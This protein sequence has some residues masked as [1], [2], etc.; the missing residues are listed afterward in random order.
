MGF[1]QP[2]DLDGRVSLVTGA[3]SG[4]G[5]QLAHAMASAGARVMCAD[6]N[7]DGAQRTADQLR[8]SGAEA[9]AATC[10]V[11]QEGEVE[12]LVAATLRRFGQIDILFN[13]AGVSES[14]PARAHEYATE[15][16]HRLIDIDLHGLF[17][18]AKHTLAPMVEAGRGKIVNTASIWGMSGAAELFPAPGYTAAKGAV[19]NLT[20][21]L[22]LQ[23]AGD[24][25]QV[26][27]ICPGFFSTRLADG[28]YDDPDFVASASAFTPM[29]R[30]ARA[31]EIRGT[32]IFLASSAS[33]FMTGQT[34]VLDGGVLAK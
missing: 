11:T 14:R 12:D 24:N 32:A 8:T 16:W 33:D 6:V 31:E 10:D 23:Y 26:N 28:I 34:V 18:C 17:Y 22:G 21:E 1:P 30:I 25:I 27:A 5:V 15:D 4:L 29:G 2:F 19:V 13:N 3:A 7:G 20:R 9:D